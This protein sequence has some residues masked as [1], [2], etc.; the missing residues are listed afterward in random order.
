M[1]RSMSCIRQLARLEPGISWAEVGST[2][3]LANRMLL[4]MGRPKV[5]HQRLNGKT[6]DLVT[7]SASYGQ[8]S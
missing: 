2:N 1:K 6:P 5:L 3:H 7:G 4:Y 8:S